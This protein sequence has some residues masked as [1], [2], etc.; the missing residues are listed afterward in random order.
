[1]NCLDKMFVAQKKSN[2]I[3]LSQL[4]KS[5]LQQMFRGSRNKIWNR[6]NHMKKQN[7]KHQNTTL[8]DEKLKTMSLMFFASFFHGIWKISNS[9]MWT[10]KLGV[11]FLFWVDFISDDSRF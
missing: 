11:S 4:S 1:M 3:C 2:Q 5:S 6:L 10:A 7:K 8:I 9:N